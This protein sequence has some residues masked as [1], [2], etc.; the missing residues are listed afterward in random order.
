MQ[1]RCFIIIPTSEPEGYAQGH[2]NRVYDYIIVPACRLAGFSPER[3][4]NMG[5]L[6][7][8]ADI[9]KSITDSDIA[10][11]DLSSKNKNSLYGIAIRYSLNLPL[12]LVKDMKTPILFDI[13]DFTV[14]DYDESLRIDT[15]QNEVELLRQNLEKAYANKKETNPLL[16]RLGIGPGSTKIIEETNIAEAESE[17]EKPEPKPA[18]LPIISPLPDYV[19]DPLTD[20]DIEKIKKGDV[21]F[22]MNHGRGEINTLKKTGKDKI[23][24]IEFESGPKILVLGT[25]GF[26]RKVDK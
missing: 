23:A 13:V 3:A 4:D 12:V 15:V 14:V 20:E 21:I 18:P 9:I 19:G 6:E 17:A 2:F 25:S 24:N 8:P 10:V 7:S 5:V 1:K 26:F 11:C 16:T 22:H